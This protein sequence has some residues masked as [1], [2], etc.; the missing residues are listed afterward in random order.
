MMQTGCDQGAAW[1][2][3]R[4]PDPATMTPAERDQLEAPVR[5]LR[6]AHDSAVMLPVD[7]PLAHY[8]RT[9]TRFLI[10]EVGARIGAAPGYVDPRQLVERARGVIAAH[11]A[12]TAEMQRPMGRCPAGGV[13]G[14]A[15]RAAKAAREAAKAAGAG[16]SDGSSRLQI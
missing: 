7:E 6:G 10:G 13:P 16:Q 14:G 4:S 15:D 8:A 12:R 3:P 9:A 2:G 5:I 1:P 11:D